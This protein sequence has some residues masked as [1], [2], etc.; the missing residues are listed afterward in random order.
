M[1]KLAFEDHWRE[2]NCLI[3]VYDERGANC[4]R[5]IFSSQEEKE[6]LDQRTIK[7]TLRALARTFAVDL[8]ALRFNYGPLVN[9]KTSLPLPLHPEFILVPL[10]ARVPHWTDHGAWGYFVL[11]KIAGYKSDAAHAKTEITFTSSSKVT[12]LQSVTSVKAILNDAHI[13]KTVYKNRL[14]P[15]NDTVRECAY[16]YYR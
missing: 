3:P 6:F 7:S 8:E 16:H 11:D 13:L 10:K 12:I 14:S 15:K 9:R 5:V 2:L 4:T 1:A